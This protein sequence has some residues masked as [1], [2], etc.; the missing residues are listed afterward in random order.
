M[1]TLDNNLLLELSKRSDVLQKFPELNAIKNVKSCCNRNKNMVYND[2][3]EA[4]SLLPEQRQRQLIQVLGNS[5]T[6]VYRIGKSTKSVVFN[7]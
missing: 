2:V 6:V 5:V 7:K 4:L 3:K 1:I